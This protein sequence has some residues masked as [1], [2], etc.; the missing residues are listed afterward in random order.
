MCIRDSHLIDTL[1]KK[2]MQYVEPVLESYR[3][4]TFTHNIENLLKS[5][6]EFSIGAPQLHRMAEDFATKNQ[7][8]VSEFIE[9]YRP[10]ATNIY[11]AMLEHARENG[12]LREDINIPI[13][14][15]FISTLIIQTTVL[16]M[17][18]LD[19]LKT[20]DIAIREV[21]SFIEHAVLKQ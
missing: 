5:G 19:T 4:H 9:K 13:T 1:Y 20:S 12:E 10:E 2:K 6:L 8:F 21:L 7:S 16:L 11:I 17:G 14:S 3:E 18:R 15:F